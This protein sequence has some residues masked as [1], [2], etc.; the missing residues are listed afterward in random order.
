[1]TNRRDFLKH[2]ALFGAA[3]ACTPV[4]RSFGAEAA[5]LTARAATDTYTVNMDIVGAKSIPPRQIVLP[6]VEGFKTLKGD[7]HIH[8]LF[9]DGNVMPRDRVDEAIQNGL[10]VIAIT[11]HIEYRPF[12]SRNGKWKLTAEQADNYNLSYEIAKPEAEKRNLLLIRGTEITKS[13]MAPGHFNALFVDDVNP[14]AAAVDDWRKM[15][16][17]AAGQGAFLLWNHPGWE[18][19]RSGGIEKGAPLRFTR[20]HEDAHRRGWLHGVELFNHKEYYP[21]VS[22]WCNE[23]DLA[24]FANSDIHDSELSTYGIQN[25][26]RPIT[27]VLAKERSLDSVKEALFARRTIG[28]AGGN[29]WGREPWLPALFKASVEIKN[30]DPGT[31]KLTN[32]TS[33]PVSVSL[34]GVRLDLPKDVARPV[35]RAW[36]AKRLV[37]TNWLTGMHRPLEIAL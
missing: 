27:L 31:I 28:W 13:T 21:V 2:A 26:L 25:P 1:M 4:S 36:D 14:I 12:F 3:A 8:T 19:P 5:G 24:I 23:R 33:L 35:Y 20:E 22:D 34:G 15:L 16:E 17:V 32:R 11:D 6:D 7:F 9:S 10:D 29:I 30:V 18:A 37:V